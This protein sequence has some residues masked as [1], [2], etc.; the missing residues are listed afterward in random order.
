MTEELSV[1]WEKILR[2]HCEAQG[3]GSRV[4]KLT[5]RGLNIRFKSLTRPIFV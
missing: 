5:L 4:D 1:P 3:K 2:S